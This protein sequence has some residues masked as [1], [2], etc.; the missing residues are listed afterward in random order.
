MSKKSFTVNLNEELI[1]KIKKLA[2]MNELKTSEL[3]SWVLSNFVN[4]FDIL[5][6]KTKTEQTAE[7]DDEEYVKY[8]KSLRKFLSTGDIPKD[9]KE[10]LV[11]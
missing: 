3:V 7:S 4:N 8:Y 10:F 6:E 2:K 5:K 1:A 11:G 9:A